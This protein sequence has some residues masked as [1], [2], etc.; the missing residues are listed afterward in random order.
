MEK[1][2]YKIIILFAFIFL[3]TIN[4][5]EEHNIT[6]GGEDAYARSGDLIPCWSQSKINLTY[7]Y[8]NC[9][10]CTTVQF[11]RGLAPQSECTTSNPGEE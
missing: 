1:I 7:D 11:R 9:T 10:T 5:S 2:K 8:T 4:L 3:I 6:I